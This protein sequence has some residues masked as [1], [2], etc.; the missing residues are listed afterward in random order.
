MRRLCTRTMGDGQDADEA[1]LDRLALPEQRAA[2]DCN[3][4]CGNRDRAERAVEETAD[5]A[6]FISLVLGRLG[7]LSRR[8]DRS[9]RRANALHGRRFERTRTG[10]VAIRGV[11]V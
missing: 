5:A 8:T 2:D 10:E 11:V 9:W 6:P 1:R 3:Q 4:H 7:R